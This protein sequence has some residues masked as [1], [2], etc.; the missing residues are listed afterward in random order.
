MLVLSLGHFIHLRR[1]SK[2]LNIAEDE[3]S[4]YK[5][6]DEDIGPSKIVWRL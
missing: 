4:I 6:F 3:Y 2:Y 5:P 1:L